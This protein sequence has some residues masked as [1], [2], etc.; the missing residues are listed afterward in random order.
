MRSDM[1]LTTVNASKVLLL[2]ALCCL[3]GCGERQ[4]HSATSSPAADFA[5]LAL[6]NGGSYAVDADRSKPFERQESNHAGQ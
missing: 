4:G 2:S 5:D 3:T 1:R 6:L